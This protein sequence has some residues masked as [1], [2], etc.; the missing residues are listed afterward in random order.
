MLD[1]RVLQRLHRLSLLA[2]RASGRSLLDACG[3]GVAAGTEQAGLRDYAPGDD[4][5]HIDWTLCARRD[6]L[7]TKTFQGDPNRHVYVLLDCSASMGQGTPPKFTLARQIA[8]TLAY[9]AATRWERISLSAF[10]DGL[11]ASAP[12]ARHPGRLPALLRFLG[13]LSPQGRAS[14]L[15]RAVQ[16]FVRRYQ[17]HGPVVVISDLYMQNG[18]APAFDLLRYR[19]YSPHLIEIG[20]PEEAHPTRLGDLELYDV[21][22]GASRRVTVTQRALKR[23]VELHRQFRQSIVDYCSRAAMRHLRFDCAAPED[24]VLLTV[25][26]ARAA[27]TA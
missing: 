23:Y 19:G 1:E 8:A 3:P 17:R 14:D 24:E 12:P 10:S 11:V 16:A 18:F 7:L 4:F 13:E 5:R 15:M 22:R 27:A 25:L 26:G 2:R 21:E 20:D 9:I 6:E